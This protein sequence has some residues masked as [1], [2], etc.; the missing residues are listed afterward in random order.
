MPGGIVKAI[1]SKPISKGLTKTKLKS[2]HLQ[3]GIFWA[4]AQ[5]VTRTKS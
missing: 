5:E 3:M 4:M 1:P 2:H